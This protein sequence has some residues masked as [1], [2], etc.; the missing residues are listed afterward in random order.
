MN[1][2]QLI[3]FTFLIFFL[4]SLSQASSYLV[5]FKNGRVLKVSNKQDN[6]EWYRFG[7]AHG[8]IGV[9]K[10]QVEKIVESE[11]PDSTSRLKG[12]SSQNRRPDPASSVNSSLPNGQTNK[13][14]PP[15]PRSVTT[16]NK[17]SSPVFSE[18]VNAAEKKQLSEEQA[19]KVERFQQQTQKIRNRL[20]NNPRTV[21]K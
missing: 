3:I 11:I 17:S 4:F 5:Y 13:T 7:V 1:K 2:K 19:A 8:Q 12:K 18:E 21:S 20:R 14:L 16:E 10:S 9:P 15:Q 6:G